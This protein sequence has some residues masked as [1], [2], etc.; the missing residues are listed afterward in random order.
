MD[1]IQFRIDWDLLAEVL[2]TLAVLAFFVERALSV[3]FESKLFIDSND[4]S[5]QH[6][7]V[8]HPKFGMAGRQVIRKK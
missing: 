8:I 5:F 3:V 4:K 6:L 2:V 7:D 1:P